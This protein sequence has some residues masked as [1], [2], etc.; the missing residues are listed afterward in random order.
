VKCKNYIYAER[1]CSRLLMRNHLSHHDANISNHTYTYIYPHYLQITEESRKQQ[2]EL[3]AAVRN[4][5]RL[6]ALNAQLDNSLETAHAE[7]RLVKERIDEHIAMAAR[8]TS[9]GRCVFRSICI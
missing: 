8:A 3:E 4:G 1:I 6:E 5:K 7:V 9:E 2:T